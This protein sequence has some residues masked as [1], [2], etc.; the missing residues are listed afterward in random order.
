M[1]WFSVRAGPSVL[2][3]AQVLADGGIIASQLAASLEARRSRAAGHIDRDAIIA[4]YD[5]PRR[6]RTERQGAGRQS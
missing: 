5:R 3:V 2:E 1:T 4:A 6:S